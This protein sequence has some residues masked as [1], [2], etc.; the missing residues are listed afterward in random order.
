VDK[1]NIINLIA[2][3]RNIGSAP[4]AASKILFTVDGGDPLYASHSFSVSALEPG[5]T[6]SLTRQVYEPGPKSYIA[7]ATVDS[8]YLVAESNEAN[9]TASITFTVNSQGGLS[10]IGADAGPTDTGIRTGTGGIAGTGGS[11]GTGGTMG[12]GGTTGSGGNAGA[13]VAFTAGRA[14]GAMSGYGWVELGSADTITD[15]TCGLSKS[16][17]TTL[18]PCLA[19]ANW[20]TADRLCV[21][22][23]IPALPAAPTAIDYSD[24]PGITVGVNATNP[25]GGG[26]GQTFATVRIALSGAPTTGLRAVVHRTG[27]A[28]AIIYC[29]ALT[30]GIAIALTSF[31]TTCWSASG[32]ALTYADV[33]HID[34]IGVLIPSGATAM[35]IANLCLAGI[36]FAD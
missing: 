10:V 30:P 14:S 22:G 15:P 21:S 29:A 23:T 19:N 7:H 26:L 33:A 12:T 8:Q 36:T 13:T 3:V 9:N 34:R 5:V 2:V 35:A 17:I 6:D 31:K 25:A 32:T 1:G 27:D 20:S 4:A 28:D 11:T 16:P 24:N 18:N